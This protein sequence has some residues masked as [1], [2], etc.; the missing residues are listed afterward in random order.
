MPTTAPVAIPTPQPGQ[1]RQMSTSK[2]F[3]GLSQCR[4]QSG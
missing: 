1:R 3:V 2:D 4:V